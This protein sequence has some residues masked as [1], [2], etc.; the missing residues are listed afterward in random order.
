LAL[1]Y[2][3]DAQ[4]AV[5][6]IDKLDADVRPL[7]QSR[8]DSI[9]HREV[10]LHN[11]VSKR[12]N[13]LS[14]LR[15]VDSPEHTNII[16]E[17]C[18]ED[19]LFY[20]ITESGRYV[21]DDDLVKHVFL[22]IIDA[23]EHCHSLSVY[24][25]D[26]RPENILVADG[27]RTVKL[28]DLGNATSDPV[29]SLFGCGAAFYMSP[30]TFSSSKAENSLVADIPNMLTWLRVAAEVLQVGSPGQ[31]FRCAPNDVWS[32]GIVLINL[33]CRRNP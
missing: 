20:N 7:N 24:H 14:I 33:V 15:I 17:Y 6:S 1:D 10:K 25:R 19:D 11:P 3:T 2:K 23:V 5:R 18:P 27:G 21:G 22:Q 9:I 16:L 13:V 4:Y 31:S 29:S 12:P 28:A 8:I 30:G 32:L 26:L